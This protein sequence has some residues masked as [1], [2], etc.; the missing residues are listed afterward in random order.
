MKH[1]M[2]THIPTSQCARCHNRSGRIGLSY[3]GLMESDPYGTPFQEGRFNKTR[4]SALRSVIHMVPDIH[5]EKGMHCIDCHTSWDVMGEGNIYSRMEE[6]VE[7][8]CWDC[9]GTGSDPP[10]KRVIGD[11]NDYAVWASQTFPWWSVEPEDEV[12][13]SSRGRPLINVINVPTGWVLHGKV[14]GKIHPVQV[15]T[16]KPGPHTMPGH[17]RLECSARHSSW[18]PQCYGCHDYRFK[19]K[20]QLDPNTGISTSGRWR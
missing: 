16:G 17:E 8:R 11:D 9:H 5:F 2:T 15:I 1:Q 4:L 19:A 12:A 10:S 14:D 7:I 20:K 18:A 3:Q 13:V 6:Q